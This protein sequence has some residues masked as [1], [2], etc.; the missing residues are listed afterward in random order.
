M[1]QETS[2]DKTEYQVRNEKLHQIRQLDIDPFPT[3]A[4]EDRKDIF[5]IRSEV[6][7]KL[8]KPQDHDDQEYVAAGRIRSIRTQGALTFIDLEDGTGK[9]QALLK[10]EVV[11]EKAFTQFVELIDGGDC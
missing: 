10:L 1:N 2:K 6:A 8:T 7:A 4:W 11:G 3:K 9:I 5:E